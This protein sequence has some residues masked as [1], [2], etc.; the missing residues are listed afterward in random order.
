MTTLLSAEALKLRTLRMAG[1]AALVAVA[2]SAVVGFAGVRIAADAGEPAPLTAV[3]AAPAQVLWFLAIVVA[4]LASSGE[5]QH[6]TVRTTMLAEPRRARVLAAKGVVAGAYG[7]LL[8]LLGTASAVVAGLVTAAASGE[9]LTGGGSWGHVAA[10]I[11][12]GAAFAVLA[13]GLGVLTRSTAAAIAAVLLWRFVGEGILPLVLRADD[14]TRW[15]PS[16]AAG[17]LVGTGADPLAPW[18]GGLVLAGYAA[19]V[20]GLAALLFVRRDPT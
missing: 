15:T 4:V 19:A 17:G 14:L 1:I 7:A 10:G 18:A 20:C 9:T 3:A 12:V 2:V 16:G 11:G 8:V 6:R 13:T 5:F